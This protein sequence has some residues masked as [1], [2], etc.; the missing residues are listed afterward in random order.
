MLVAVGTAATTHI[1]AIECDV[2][3]ELPP[4]KAYLKEGFTAFCGPTLSRQ[5]LFVPFP[6]LIEGSQAA[7]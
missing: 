6:S 1:A 3:I 2:A 4:V 5:C 7:H